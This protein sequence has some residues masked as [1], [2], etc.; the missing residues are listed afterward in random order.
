M[1]AP[2]TLMP[3]VVSPTGA[4][5][6][7]A[8]PPT[9][10]SS[11]RRVKELLGDAFAFV[12]SAELNKAMS[13]VTIDDLI[14][15][16]I[17]RNGETATINKYSFNPYSY[18]PAAAPPAGLIPEGAANFLSGADTRRATKLELITAL[19]NEIVLLVDEMLR[20][21][22]QQ[23]VDTDDYIEILSDVLPEE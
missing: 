16:Q 13:A 14:V 5:D 4:E 17:K 7:N 18:N 23:L 15:D 10:I 8:G 2:D 6:M 20:T 22:V 21:P 1:T 11:S 12:R 9:P 19:N 3:D